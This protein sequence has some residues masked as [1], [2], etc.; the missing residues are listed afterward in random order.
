LALQ[1]PWIAA[2]VGCVSSDAQLVHL[3]IARFAKAHE[4]G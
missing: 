1:L 2:L 3:H 4:L